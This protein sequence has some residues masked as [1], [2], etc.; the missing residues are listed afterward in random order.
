VYDHI[1]EYLVVN[2][3]PLQFLNLLLEGFNCNET[4]ILLFFVGSL[5]LSLHIAQSVMSPKKSLGLL[6]GLL[7]GDQIW[8]GETDNWLQKGRAVSN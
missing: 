5:W 1:K 4:S 7:L 3:L 6:V 2:Q 8:G